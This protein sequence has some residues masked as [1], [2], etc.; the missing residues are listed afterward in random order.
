MNTVKK[1]QTKSKCQTL[2]FVPQETPA[3]TIDQEIAKEPIRIRTKNLKGGNKSIYLDFYNEGRREYKFLK[4]Y[5]IPEK[6][7]QDK[8]QNRETMKAAMTIKSEMIVNFNRKKAGIRDEKNSKITL[9]EWLKE[10]QLDYQRKGRVESEHM[11]TT[12][13]VLLKMGKGIDKVRL[14]NVDKDLCLDILNFLKYDYISMKGTRLSPGGA[15]LY[16][17]NINC[18]LNIAFKK[19]LIDKNPFDLV[20]KCDKISVPDPNRAFLT[21]EEVKKLEDSD[22]YAHIKNLFL[23]SCY[24]GLR[25]SDISNLTWGNVIYDGDD[26][27]LNII[28]QK[29]HNFLVVPLCKKAIQYLPQKPEKINP[30]EKVFTLT[31][32]ENINIHIKKWMKKVGI[33]KNVSMH[34][35]RH[36]FATLLLTQDVPIKVIQELLGH[37]EIE[38]TLIYA[39]LVDKKKNE[40][41]NRLDI[42]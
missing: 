38:T 6:T 35:A 10:V 12:I 32:R 24:Y 16:Y 25:I 42:I 21:R 41:V 11:G 30:N 5:L 17:K 2:K 8:E 26:V 18:A 34:T 4:M 37:S 3:K 28:V 15:H 7:K 36:T 19:E 39:K 27:T 23:F 22:Y 13:N 1:D 33:T 20:D 31:T 9:I 29:T 40:A 14:G